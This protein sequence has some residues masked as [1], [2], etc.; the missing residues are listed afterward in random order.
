MTCIQVYLLH[1]V[2]DL[3]HNLRISYNAMCEFTDNIGSLDAL[4]KRPLTGY[5]GLVWAGINACGNRVVTVEEAGDLC[6]Q[7]VSEIGHQA[8]L[9]KMKWLIEESGWMSDKPAKN[10]KAAKKASPKS[11]PATPE[12]PSVS[13]D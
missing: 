8:F 7:L 10:P 6:E 1:P 3:C 9:M 2:L 12:P 4:E 11:S 13:E 5:R